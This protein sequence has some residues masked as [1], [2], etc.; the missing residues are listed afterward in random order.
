MPGRFACVT[1]PPMNADLLSDAHFS[2]P[3][4]GLIWSWRMLSAAQL[5][6]L[7]PFVVAADPSG[8]DARSWQRDALA[9]LDMRPTARGII[10]VQC[11][12][13]F[14]LALFFY[15]VPHAE[16]RRLAIERLRWLE[17]A[18]PH[19]S[20]DALL[21]IIAEQ[22][23]NFSC[24]EVVIAAGAVTERS[25]RDALAERAEMAGF[26]VDQSSWRRPLGH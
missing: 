10:S 15:A 2:I 13:G 25:A 21:A 24:D 12:A 22:A 26:V 20:L 11:V 7:L 14:T 1:A 16:G 17:L 9:W 5:E 19:R 8:N 18:R 23:R 3:V 6:P 4:D